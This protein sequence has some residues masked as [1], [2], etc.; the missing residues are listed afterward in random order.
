LPGIK[1]LYALTTAQ[2]RTDNDTLG[3]P[4]GVKHQNLNRIAE[5]IVIKLIVA[6]PVQPHGCVGRYHE[7]K[8]GPGWTA[9]CER[10]RQRAECDQLFAHESHAHEPTRCVRFEFEERA[11]LFGS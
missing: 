10:R 8:S 2:I 6:D 5:V 9:F 4:T 7:V 1:K 3:R 11:D